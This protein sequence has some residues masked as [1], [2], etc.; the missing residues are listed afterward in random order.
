MIT[1]P[2]CNKEL[3]D[4]TKFCSGC[5]SNVTSTPVVEETPAVETPV[6][7][8][9][10]A[11]T[12]VV[13]PTTDTT[14]AP[15]PEDIVAKAKKLPLKLIGMVA[16]IVVLVIL[17][18]TLIS[19]LFS[20]GKD[21]EYVVYLKDDQLYISLLNK[22]GIEITKDLADGYSTDSILSDLDEITSLIH[23][24]SDKKTIIYPDKLSG[25][26]FTLYFRNAKNEKADAEK[27]DSGITSYRVS[28]NDKTIIYLTE[29]DKLYTYNFKD[30]EKL[31]SDVN[32]FYMTD[33]AKTILY[34]DYDG[35]IYLMK[36]GKEEK[37]AK[38]A[39][40]EGFTEGMKTIFFTKEGK[41]YVKEGSNDEE[42][43]DSDVYDV[44][45]VYDNGTAYFVKNE[46]ETVC[47]LDYVNDDMAS[48]D[49]SMTEPV[50]PD[51]DDFYPEYPYSFDWMNYEEYAGCANWD[52]AYE[53]Y[54]QLYEAADDA[55]DAAYDAY[56]DAYDA[57]WDKENR[58]DL[59]EDLADYTIDVDSYTLYYLDGKEAVEVAKDFTYSNYDFSSKDS[60]P[61]IAFSTA[62]A[63]DVEKLNISEI[64]YYWDVEEHVLYAD[65]EISLNVA[66]KGTATPVELED[67][68]TLALSSDGKTLYV[69]A[70]EE[71][72]EYVATLYKA[73][74]SSKVGKFE[75]YD[76]DIYSEYLSILENGN[77]LYTK[78]DGEELYV[79]KTLIDDDF[80]MSTLRACNEGDILYYLSDVKD[81]EGTLEISKNGKEGQE[82]ADDVFVV[83]STTSEGNV[84]YLTDYDTDD[85]EGTLNFSK[86]GGEGK[87]IDEDVQSMISPLPTNYWYFYYYY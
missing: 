17:G 25:G 26:E 29:D 60:S 70:D 65:K 6:A 16:G 13:E 74:I 84:I 33:D 30:K 47:L 41:L 77:V 15:S 11:E 85:Y 40:L 71:D 3:P 45:T 10:V 66:V 75:A 38:D 43:I 20:G 22:E 56:W 14:N 86:N 87:V 78:E 53:L 2:K 81:S 31:A 73:S 7:E 35:N 42:K 67:I 72:D 49:A 44:L 19:N 8:T 61:V 46:S 55:Y 34:V 4:G 80:A 76:E 58:D 63:E 57:W 32:Y 9:P 18:I 24:T 59:R 12:P 69:A 54:L 28:E 36:N 52:E 23:L 5:G 48:T 21:P 39:S 83:Y 79:N 27:I 51:Y 50:Y 82:I 1:C 37:I 64:Y 68:S 62:T